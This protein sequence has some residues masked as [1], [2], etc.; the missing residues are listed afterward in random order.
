[1]LVDHRRKLTDEQHKEIAEYYLNK[2]YTQVQLAAMYNVTQV[3]ICHII[4][5]HYRN[6]KEQ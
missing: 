3:T 5:K 1:M 2:E 6:L 4:K